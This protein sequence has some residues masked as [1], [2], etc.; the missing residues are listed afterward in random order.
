MA[1][2]DMLGDG[3]GTIRFQQM[4]AQGGLNYALQNYHTLWSKDIN[5]YDENKWF[6]NLMDSEDLIKISKFMYTREK[7]TL[8]LYTE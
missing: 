7:R 5:D 6:I 3:D 2:F 1:L 8:L 4:H